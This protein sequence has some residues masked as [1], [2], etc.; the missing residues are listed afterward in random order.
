MKHCSLGINE[1]FPKIQTASS[2]PRELNKGKGVEEF[3]IF[4]H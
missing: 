4:N 3:T 1:A 2:Q